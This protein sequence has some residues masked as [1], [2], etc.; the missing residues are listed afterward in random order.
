MALRPLI[1]SARRPHRLVLGVPDVRAAFP[2]LLLARQAARHTVS[3]ADWSAARSPWKQFRETPRAAGIASRSMR[4]GEGVAR[5]PF[6]VVFKA[7]RAAS[8]GPGRQPPALP[9]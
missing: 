3:W 9:W 5:A 7:P 8:H 4:G 1:G 6:L 2:S